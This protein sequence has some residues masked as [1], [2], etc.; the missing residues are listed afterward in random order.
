M[1]ILRIIWEAGSLSHSLSLSGTQKK[2]WRQ[3]I[4]HHLTLV[5]PFDTFTVWGQFS[6]WFISDAG[7]DGDLSTKPENFVILKNYAAVLECSTNSGEQYVQWRY[8]NYITP[9]EDAPETDAVNSECLPEVTFVNTNLPKYG[10]CHLLVYD[11]EN[12]YTHRYVCTDVRE[13]F[14]GIVMVL[15]KIWT[16]NFHLKS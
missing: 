10:A 7:A 12:N 9:N 11:T 8:Q 5:Q 2:S 4:F 15:G 6:R 13:T 1:G 16:E 14:H 3:E